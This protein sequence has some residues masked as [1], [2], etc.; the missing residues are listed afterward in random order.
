MTTITLLNDTASHV[1]NGAPV[2][3][4]AEGDYLTITFPNSR[5]ARVNGGNNS[6]TIA[7]NSVGNVAVVK[8]KV[9]RGGEDDARF[10]SAQEQAG[11]TV[12]NATIRRDYLRDGVE[13]V[14]SFIMENGSFTDAPEFKENN[15]VPEGM[16]EYTI[17]YRNCIRAL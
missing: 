4:V 9:T 7:K 16:V 6:V 13:A 3:D 5:T 8:F 17:E 12:F 14:E 15:T 1:I 2:R 11:A 10:S